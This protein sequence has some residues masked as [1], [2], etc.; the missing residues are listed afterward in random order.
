[1]S[2]SGVNQFLSSRKALPD[3]IKTELTQVTD[4]GLWM[5]HSIHVTKADIVTAQYLI[6]E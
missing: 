3:V 1:M 6:P 4:I 2:L 5:A